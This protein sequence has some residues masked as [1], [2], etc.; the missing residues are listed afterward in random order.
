[1]Y[2]KLIIDGPY[3]AHK[4]N[5][6]KHRLL[7]SHNIDSSMIHIFLSTLRHIHKTFSIGQTQ[8]AWESHGTPSWRKA[9][10]P[11]YKPSR[12]AD[13]LYLSQLPDLQAI[14]QPLKI[15]QFYS[16]KNDADDVIAS[17][18]SFANKTLIYT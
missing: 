1:M 14:L 13:S 10:L 3:L 2:D 4:S 8:I 6:V 15:P 18:S 9:I 12:P 17:L 16:P 11:T 5:C 7:T